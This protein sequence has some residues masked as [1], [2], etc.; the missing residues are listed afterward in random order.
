MY[1]A[2]K[3]TFPNAK[4]YMGITSIN[5]LRRWENGFGYRKQTVMF[6]AI[7]KY[8]WDNIQYEILFDGL[9]KEE[10]C[11]KEIEL[12]ALYK[13]NNPEYGYNRDCGGNCPTEEVK[14]H[15]REVNLGKHHSEESKR[16]MSESRK[17]RTSWNKGKRMPAGT[18]EKAGEKQSIVTY[19]YSKD[20]ELIAI[21]KSVREAARKTG[22]QSGSIGRCC[23][24]ILKTTGGY[25]WRHEEIC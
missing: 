23:K 15:L 1:C 4:I 12:I 19:Q 20:G 18:G 6:R 7:C 24:G 5:P 8:G 13:S 10:A 21:Y 25:V 14:Q 22:L 17:G 2:Y 11:Q 9:T 16:K 3:H